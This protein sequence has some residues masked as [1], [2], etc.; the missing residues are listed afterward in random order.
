M[1]GAL[2]CAR[3]YPAAKKALSVHYNVAERLKKHLAQALQDQA[4]QVETALL[5]DTACPFDAD[6][7]IDGLIARAVPVHMPVRLLVLQSLCGGGLKAKRYEAVRRDLVQQYGFRL[8]PGL[9]NLH[10]LGLLRPYDRSAPAPPVDLKV[11]RAKLRLVEPNPGYDCVD[12]ADLHF[13]YT[14]YAPL[15]VRLVQA[16]LH[17]LPGPGSDPARAADLLK[18]VPGAPLTQLEQ[19][20][21][22]AKEDKAVGKKHVTLV[23]MVGGMTHAEVSALR[24]LGERDPN[25]EFLALTT[26]LTDCKSFLAALLDDLPS[27]NADEGAQ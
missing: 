16:L 24:W 20:T 3:V 12:P 14:Q 9:D 2:T 27:A 7:F 13:A 6:A 25:R 1:G 22:A 23:C 19:R 10:E 4:L 18:A 5:T 26:R 21:G 8:L 17:T 15:S 11:A